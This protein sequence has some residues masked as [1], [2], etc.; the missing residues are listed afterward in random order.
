ML[1]TWT[2]KRVGACTV[3][4]LMLP[5]SFTVLPMQCRTDALAAANG[6]DDEQCSNDK[7]ARPSTRVG[8]GDVLNKQR[9]AVC[10]A[11]EGDELWDNTKGSTARTLK[12]TSAE[13][14]ECGP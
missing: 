14:A 13:A 5:H 3:M 2:A 9:Q 12:E 8:I 4:P 7:L 1:N 11:A 10:S 6:V